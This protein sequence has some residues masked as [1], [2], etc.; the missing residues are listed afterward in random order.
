MLKKGLCLL[1]SIAF[2]GLCGWAGADEA[3][4]FA[5]AGFDGDSSTHDWN[6]NQFFTRM[7]SRTG[8]SFTFSEYT[9]YDEWQKAKTD[10][11]SSGGA[12][13]D[14]L[15]KAELSTSELIRY[16]DSGQLIDLMP[17]LPEYAP[18]LWAV[19]QAHPDWLKAITLPSGKI[20]ALPALNTQPAQNAMWINKTWLDRLGLEA[21]TDTQSLREVLTAFRDNDPNQNGKKDEVPM[22][23]LGAWD[24]KFLGH[25]FGL[26]ANDYNLYV[27]E[28]G[29]VCYAPQQDSYFE[30]LSYLRGLYQD[31]L[32]HKDGFYTSD[33]LR[34]IT[35]EKSAEIYGI[36]FSPN[37]MTLI[38]YSQ[39]TD[40]V[41]LEPLVYNGKQ[42]YRNLFGEVTRGTF[43]ITS[44]CENPGELLRWV[45]TLYTE[46]GAIEAFA[47]TE[48]QDY[49]FSEEGTWDWVGGQEAMSSSKLTDLSLYDTG[50]MPWLFPK[51]FY[52]R[53][54]AESIQRV[55]QEL[56]K[57]AVFVQTPF[58]TSYTLTAE[59]ETQAVD[60]QRTLGRYVDESFAKFVI[61]QTPLT[62]ESVAA[63]KEGLEERGVSQFLSFWQE[64]YAQSGKD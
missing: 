59:Q 32:L 60:M 49:E 23:F 46:E 48:N 34:T 39:N 56:E 20:G 41:L 42:I 43:A 50:N 36:M 44:A 6:T 40:Y 38:P 55:Y 37:P 28:A 11:F 54:A 33:S 17:L 9:S 10:M 22:T 26:I 35:D 15:F 61:G 1:L 5:M 18:N 16:T 45:D 53:Y 57:L 30:L 8:V 27:D 62:E 3:H 13:P 58:P 24:L 51:D 64:I 21:P 4:T 52:S 31:G 47:G 19:L 25:A 29:E 12:L 2:L 14:V 63:F 7:Q